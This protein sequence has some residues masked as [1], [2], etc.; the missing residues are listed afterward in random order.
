MYLS[1]NIITSKHYLVHFVSLYSLGIYLAVSFG[2][3][4]SSII[5][6]SVC[7][8]WVCMFFILKNQSKLRYKYIVL[9]FLLIFAALLGIFRI[10]CTD[11]IQTNSLRKYAG[12]EIWI[13]GTV[14]SEPR[15]TSSGHFCSFELYVFGAGG[16]I[17][18]FG[19]IIMYIPAETDFELSAGDNIYAWTNIKSPEEDIDPVYLD[20]HTHLR[21]RNIFLSGSAENINLL[22]DDIKITPIVALKNSGTW[23]RNQIISSINK[24]FPDNADISAILKGIL[25]GDKSG[26]SDELYEKFAYSGISHIVAVSGLHISI[27][28]SFLMV[29][30][31]RFYLNKKLNLLT[32]IPAVILFMSASALTPSVCRAGIMI[33]I[34]IFSTL[35][36]EEYNPVTSLF[37]ALG[38]ILTVAPYSLLSK[39]LVLSFTATFSIFAF[40][41][42]I[43]NL[44]KM[45]TKQKKLQTKP[46]KLISRGLRYLLSS[47]ALSLSSFIG[48]AYFLALF[49]GGISKVQFLTNLW[50]IPLVTITFCLGYVCCVIYYISPLLVTAVL[51][52]PLAWCLEAIKLTADKFGIYENMLNIPEKYINGVTASLYFGSVLIIYILLKALRDIKIEK[53]IHKRTQQ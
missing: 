45:P 2:I 44:F 36:R 42:L 49:F 47:I 29:A 37:L 1:D 32:T 22:P 28:F 35:F 41:P 8:L 9:S 30:S 27:L 13:C 3:I 18:S 50:A 46:C 53:E 6:L 25:I 48:T 20:Y 19:T 17:G 14:T 26:F 23:V 16:E 7:A 24:I 4:A 38:L 10:Y 31:K 51:K 52:H 12:K 39:S 21:G 15:I 11:Y 5:I 34:M 40:F 43:I 33:L